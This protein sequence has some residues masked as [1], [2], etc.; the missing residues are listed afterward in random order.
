MIKNK[1]EI[2]V[3]PDYIIEHALKNGNNQPKIQTSNSISNGVVAGVFFKK[4]NHEKIKKLYGGNYI[5]LWQE[6][7]NMLRQIIPL[8]NIYG[9]IELENGNLYE[10]SEEIKEEKFLSGGTIQKWKNLESLY[11]KILSYIN[12]IIQFQM[13]SGEN[14]GIETAIWNFTIDGKLFDLDPPRLL[15]HTENSSFT[16]KEDIN[17]CKRTIY[18]NFTEIGMKTNLLATVIIGMNDGNFNVPDLP[19]NWLNILTNELIQSITDKEK[20]EY[21]YKILNKKIEFKS[22]FTKHPIDIIIE[23][24]NKNKIQGGIKMKNANQDQQFIFVA[25]PSESGKSGGVNHIKSKYSQVKHLKIR[26]IFPEVYKDDGSELPYDEWYE[27]E[28]KNNFESFW[29]RYIQKTREMS[30]GA[31][32]VI[33]DTMYGV[34]EIQYLYTKLKQNL[35]VLYID[36]PESQRVERE[37]K[38]LRT[39]SPYTDRKAD[40]SITMEQV[41]E[42]TRKKD[43]KKK[44]LGTFEYKDLVYEQDGTLGVR[45]N[46]IKFS[47]V[48]ENTGTVED[49]YN[50]LD[51]FIESELTKV[52]KRQEEREAE[53][54]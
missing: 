21:I 6:N 35:S 48:I 40:L 29:D 7:Y 46:G 31:N 25:G 47:K 30:D 33:M 51:S 27:N 53:E 37:Y 12:E 49:L 32:V 34:K 3:L 18:R 36:A 26:N 41:R 14:I 28:S 2:T 39:D 20:K 50:E 23:Q 8:N 44:K 13:K 24:I 42:E 10:F 52:V 22:D 15:K 1:Y 4:L 38:R 45:Q 17:Q 11:S 16:R 5:Q 54:R 19:Q 43:E 9:L